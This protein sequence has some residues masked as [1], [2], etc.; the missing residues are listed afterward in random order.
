MSPSRYYLWAIH[1][2]ENWS[3][4]PAVTQARIQQA[5]RRVE[6]AALD[7]AGVDPGRVGRQ[8]TG[9]GAVLA[10]P[11]DI[12]RELITTKYVDALREGIE[13][14]DLDCIAAETIRLRLALHAGE[15][16]PGQDEWAGPAVITASRLVD[17]PVL[18]RVLAAATGSA[19]ALVVSDDWYRAVIAEGYAPSDGYQRVWVEAKKFADFAWI[20]V[21]G[22]SAPPGLLPEDRRDPRGSD[23]SRGGPGQGGT[24]HQGRD[25]GQGNPA[26][27]P[28]TRG[29]GNSGTIYDFR[30]SKNQDVSIGNTTNYNGP[31]DQRPGGGAR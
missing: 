7:R 8:P 6:T 21:P 23:P 5:L 15:S 30:H 3:G 2:V 1:D 27:S 19:L 10:I 26:D 17:A 28:Q 22:R 20:R 13:E 14:H 16:P 18:R 29:S 9:D 31:V 25:P 24:Q 4:R 11:G 12:P